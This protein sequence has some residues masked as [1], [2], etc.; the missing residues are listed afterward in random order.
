MGAFS[1]LEYAVARSLPPTPPVFLI[2]LDTCLTEE[3]LADLKSA[4]VMALSLIPQES[5]IG[6][7]TFGRTVQVYELAFEEMP[8]SFVFNGSKDVTTKQV[9]ALLQIGNKGAPRQP[10]QA[11]QSRTNRFLMPLSEVE[12]NITSILEELQPDP[13]PAKSDKRPLRSTGVALSIAIGLLEASVPN[14]GART[15]LFTG[16]PPTQGPGMIVSEDL[17]EPIRSHTD[18]VKDNAKYTAKAIKFYEGIAKRAVNS[19]HVVD[20]F[21]CSYDQLGYHEMQEVPKRTGGFVVLADDFTGSMFKGSFQKI[22]SRDEKGALPMA[23]NGTIE[24]QTSKELKVAGAIGHCTSLNKRNASVAETEIGMGNTNAWKLCSMDPNSSV[25]FYFEVVNQHA[26]PIAPGQKGLIQILTHYQD[27][28][29]F[30]VLRVTTIARDWADG[31]VGPNTNIALG[32]DQEAAATLMAR[33][34]V[35][36]AE[37]EEAFDILRWLDRMLIRLVNKFGNFV[38]DDPNSF[39]LAAN[40]SIYPQF[41]FHL[42]RSHFL[43]VFNNSPDETA[44]YRYILNRESV[45]NSLIMI[46]PTLESYSFEGPPVPVLLAS[47]SV[48]ADKILL[49][50]TFFRIV[51]H[52]GDTIAK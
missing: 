44:F 45:T 20:I 39:Q 7:I 23:F 38:K 15:M 37:T 3:E 26:N 12:F 24:I 35:F 8:K 9:E 27:A 51:V 43:Q 21:A 17:K 33:I 49:L 42:R 48:Q 41:M 52:N 30:K 36:K 10:G 18:L 11:P 2:V 47:T 4:L 14:S 40:F 34:A 13:A 32:F 5:L 6:L 29:G 50:D 31:A 19:G 28:A 1:T 16:G 46:Q 22:F 25:A